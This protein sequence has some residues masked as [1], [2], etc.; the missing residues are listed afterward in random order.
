MHRLAS[1]CLIVAACL[2]L[3]AAGASTLT[4]MTLKAF[5]SGAK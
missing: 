4:W 5:A 1:S 2:A 3:A